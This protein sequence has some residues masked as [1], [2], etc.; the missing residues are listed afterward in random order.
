[1]DG[2]FYVFAAAFFLS[3]FVLTRLA[4]RK[5]AAAVRALAARS[6]FHY[7][8]G[9]LPKSLT[10][11]GTPF[12]SSTKIWN[13][14]D[15]EPRGIRVIAF[16]SQVGSG[17]HSW[18]RTVIAVENDARASQVLAFIPDATIE[19]VGNWKIIY[20][21]KGVPL[22]SIFGLMPVEELES[23]VNSFKADAVR[24]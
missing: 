12:Q 4:E 9:A 2:I 22:F 23:Y 21:P 5:R 6:G 24:Q 14:I 1:M 15:G 19:S 17:K 11:Y 16:D 20:R 10:L 7:L 18:R 13:A 3:F 8:G